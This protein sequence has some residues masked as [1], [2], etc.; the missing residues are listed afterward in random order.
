[1]FRT[2]IWSGATARALGVARPLVVPQQYTRLFSASSNRSASLF[3]EVT[4]GNA[5]EVESAPV[6]AA[7]GE[8]FP[9][10]DTKLQQHYAEEAQKTRDVSEKYV[11]PLKKRLF[12]LNVAQHG[13]FK[14]N[15]VVVDRDSGKQYK[16]SLTAE[17]IDLLEPT[18]F[19]QSYRIKSSTKKATLV[20]RFVRGYSVK[21]AVNQLHFNPK[22]MA[23]E[24]EKLLKRGLEQARAS[25][26]DEDGLY[27]QALWTGSDG[28]YVKRAD[29]K[30][31]GR[32]GI[33]EHPYIHVKA[34]LKTEQTTARLAW[35]KEQARQ[36]A[37]PR[38]YLNNEPLNFKVRAFYKW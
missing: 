18:I 6:A 16:V 26:I 20:N 25:G 38:L 13:F 11:S 34:I 31:R 33:L 7:Q 1:M 30:G 36:A 4:E 22:K 32:T 29:V 5:P 2:G 10:S 23:T 17:E 12:E 19:L 8:V 27:I 21:N 15:H 24:L 37:K 14:N 35:E 3:G 28:G 9:E